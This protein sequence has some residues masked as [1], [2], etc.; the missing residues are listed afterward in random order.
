MSQTNKNSHNTGMSGF[1]EKRFK[2]SEQNTTVRI[3]IMAGIALFLGIAAQPAIHPAILAEAGMD[4]TAVFWA[5]TLSIIFTALIYAFWVNFP[6]VCGPSV[7]VTPWIAYY[8]VI[9]LGVPWEAALMCVF[10]SGV[11]FII[12]GLVGFREKILSII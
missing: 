6:F 5:T 2:L 9:Q 4:P 3:E 1:F 10:I 8:V 12:L 11:L 7:G